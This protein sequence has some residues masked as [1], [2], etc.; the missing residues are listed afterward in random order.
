MDISPKSIALI[1]ASH[2]RGK[3]GNAIAKNLIKF[4]NSFFVNPSLKSLLGKKCYSSILE[5]KPAVDMAVIAVKADIVPAVLEECGKKKVKTAVIISAGFSELGTQAS[6]NL[7]NSILGIAK[8]HR[9]RILGPNCL[10][11]IN[12]YIKLNSTFTSIPVKEGEIAFLSQSGALC[13]AVLDLAAQED[14][15]FSFFASVGNMSDLDFSDMIESLDKDSRTKVIVCYIEALKPDSGRRFI[16]VSKKCSKPIIV[17]KAGISQA[18][19]KTALTH[20]GSLASSYEIYKAAF[21][22]AGI[23]EAKSLTNALDKAKFLSKKKIEKKNVVILSNAGGPAVMAADYCEEFN[24]SLAKLPENIIEK[25][26]KV[27]PATWNKS[28]PIDIIGDADSLRYKSALESLNFDYDCLIC[29]LTPQEMS[30]PLETAKILA[31]FEKK[32]KKPVIAAFLGGKRLAKASKLL[33]KANI[34][35]FSELRRAIK[36]IA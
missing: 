13:S 27:L 36:L 35:C 23:I 9:T 2:K 3:V 11:I 26:N 32:S 19:A 7:E 24:I 8:E 12:P 15:G 18:G 22:E 14:L 6:K 16:E 30:Q 28:N 20:T 4:K 33:N 1:G 10:G 21:K 31:D 29:I 17:L 25:L 34:P 5:I